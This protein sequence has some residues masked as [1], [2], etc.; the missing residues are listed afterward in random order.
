MFKRS[1]VQAVLPGCR[2]PRPRLQK[3]R[4]HLRVSRSGRVEKLRITI[5]PSHPLRCQHRP[6]PLAA[7]G[8]GLLPS[9]LYPRRSP[10]RS[11]CT[12]E[13]QRRERHLLWWTT[14][15][16][17]CG[18]TRPSTNHPEPAV[19]RTLLSARTAEDE[20]SACKHLLKKNYSSSKGSVGNHSNHKNNNLKEHAVAT[21]AGWHSTVFQQHLWSSLFGHW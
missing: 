11:H 18:G 6:L 17:D 12:E 15:A 8:R 4:H 7:A 1:N 19:L 3:C 2:R 16:S 9:L 10:P 13:G 20:G 21:G 14:T 5:F